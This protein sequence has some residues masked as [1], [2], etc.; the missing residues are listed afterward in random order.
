MSSDRLN[1]YIAGKA[2]GQDRGFVG[3]DDIFELVRRE[4]A[5]P[6][7]SGLVLFG[8]RRIGKTSVLLQL[9]RRLSA[10][11]HCAVYFDLMD[12]AHQDLGKVLA[13]LAATMAAEAKVPRPDARLFDNDGDYFQQAFLPEFYAAVGQARRPLLLLDEFDVLDAAAHQAVAEGSAAYRLFPYLRRLMAEEH[14]LCFVFVVGRKAE[15][16]SIQFKAAFK[17]ARF[18]QISVLNEEDARRL[19]L[20]AERDKS[21]SFTEGAVTTILRLTSGHPYFTQLLCQILWDRA[22]RSGEGRAPVVDSE[23]VNATVDLALEAGEN[24]FQW[25]WDGLPPAERIIFSAVANAM[26]TRTSVSEADLLSTLQGHG[27]RMLTRELNL[28]PTTLVEWQMLSRTP[29]GDYRFFIE[30]MRQWVLVRKPLPK[31]KEELDR[32]VPLADQFYRTAEMAYRQRNL[33]TTISQLEQALR[34]NPNHVKARLL[35]GQSRYESGDIDGAVRDLEEAYKFDEDATRYTLVPI[36]LER[37]RQL[38]QNQFSSAALR[39]YQR[40]LE[41]SP[42]EQVARERVHAI[43]VQEGD[44]FLRAGDLERAREAYSGAEAWDKIS[45]LSLMLV[46]RQIERED[47]DGAVESLETLIAADPGNTAAHQQLESVRRMAGIK[48]R[49]AEALGAIAQNHWPQSVRLL[50]SIISEDAEYKDAAVL[51]VQAIEKNRAAKQPADSQRQTLEPGSN[52]DTLPRM[53]LR[54]VGAVFPQWAR[55][56]LGLIAAGSQA[57]F[58]RWEF[59]TVGH[60]V[61]NEFTRAFNLRFVAGVVIIVMLTVLPLHGLAWLV[62][63]LRNAPNRTIRS[64]IWSDFLQVCPVLVILL[65]CFCLVGWDYRGSEYNYDYYSE[66]NSNFF[67]GMVLW[68]FPSLVARHVWMT[69]SL[70]RKSEFAGNT[71]EDS[72]KAR[73]AA[74]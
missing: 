59:Y 3:R 11:S 55:V 39:A 16:L 24:V 49:Y 18:A 60:V 48:R 73:G 15:E 61:F 35:L 47:F 22:D 5:S 62:A 13:G 72:P 51:L 52:A 50:Q 2:L 44:E 36:L 9:K 31:V 71:N 65:V 70:R 10:D 68:S 20:T 56:S 17:G 6:D 19:I 8:Q 30:I 57:R 7:S 1:P 67:W 37:G 74:A 23:H 54:S 45:A 66:R 32:V 42:R 38:E 14:R 28:A 40:V 64:R 46:G 12:R 25:I 33:E 21:L 53:V 26:E 43:K 41:I 27:I 4:V 69:I 63:K 58:D 29:E 34:V